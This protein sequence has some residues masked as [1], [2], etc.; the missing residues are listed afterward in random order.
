MVS[1]EPPNRMHNCLRPTIYSYTK[2]KRRQE[3]L[4]R[5]AH[6]SHETL[7]HKAADDLSDNGEYSTV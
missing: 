6:P 1:D 2:L 4:R 5:L 3:S 7:G